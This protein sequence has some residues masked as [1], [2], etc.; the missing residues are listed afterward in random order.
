MSAGSRTSPQPGAGRRPGNLPVQLTSF[1]GRRAELGEVQALVRQAR[2][3]TL[4]GS[5]GSGKTRLAVEVA[6]SVAGEHPHGAWLAELA[7]LTGSQPVAAAVAAA[8]PVRGQESIETPACSPRPSA[9][10]A[11]SSCLTT[12]SICCPAAPR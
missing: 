10:R 5:G 8:L 12:A 3:V 6:A 7:S 4:T 9:S 11:C 1:V 2:L